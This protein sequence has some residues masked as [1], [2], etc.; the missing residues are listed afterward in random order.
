MLT[1]LLSRAKIQFFREHPANGI[2]WLL[3]EHYGSANI[4][5]VSV[6]D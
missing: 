2:P 5:Q 6:V 4:A 1:F 3:L